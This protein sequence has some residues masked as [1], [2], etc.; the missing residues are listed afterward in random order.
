MELQMK[1]LLKCNVALCM[2]DADEIGANR[3]TDIT[4]DTG[5]F[6][7]NFDH[8][9]ADLCGALGRAGVVRKMDCTQWSRSETAQVA[10]EELAALFHRVD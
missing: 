4:P 8:L 10:F 2:L 7:C 3:I 6:D 1:Q 5:M 9:A